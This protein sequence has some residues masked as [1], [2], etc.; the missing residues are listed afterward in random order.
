LLTSDQLLALAPDSSSAKAGEGLANGRKW[1]GLGA[2][3][4]A[5]W[6]ECQGSGKVPYQTRIDLRAIAFKCTCPSRKFPC[7]H[8]LGLY[9]LLA[10]DAGS[11]STGDA[12]PWVTEWI[13]A[14]AGR[15]ERKQQRDSSPDP[16]A[17]AK[18]VASREAKVGAGL[19]EL[20]LW[21]C[22]LV[23]MGI[24]GLP[25]K[26]YSFWDTP[27][28]RLVDAQAPGLARMLRELGGITATGAGWQDRFLERLGLLTLLIEGYRC[29]T[30]LPEAVRADLRTVIGF[31]EAQEELLS[32]SGVTDEWLVVGRCVEVEDR[33]R[34]QRSWLLGKRSGRTALVLHFGAGT[35]PLD[36]S[37]PT[38]AAFRGELVYYPSAQPQRALIKS[39]EPAAVF[40]PT[41]VS[42]SHAHAQYRQALARCPWIERHPMLIDGSIPGHLSGEFRL[43][44]EEGRELLLR[45]LPQSLWKL[46]VVSGGRPLAVFGE[47]DGC[48]LRP[49]TAWSKSGLVILETAA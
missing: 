9:L 2:N 22:D 20:E 27:A 7:K 12:P 1:S 47:W 21:M 3:E 5:A 35:E 43:L 29:G 4:T 32:Q 17:Q 31:T 14:R 36:T 25:G 10:S 6:G 13:A 38:G 30:K 19:E 39:R 18:R 11:F 42:L 40:C 24:A 34:V 48:G 46:V 37:L 33:L 44:D 41:G 8:G 45:G 26:D 16:E 49:M 28:A 23:R 15:T